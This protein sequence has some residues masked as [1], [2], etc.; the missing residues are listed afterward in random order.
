MFTSWTIPNGAIIH[1]LFYCPT[2]S[3]SSWILAWLNI[4]LPHQWFVVSK[5]LE[6]G[7]NN[8]VTEMSN[9][10]KNCQPL[11]IIR[12]PL[13]LLSL[14]SFLPY[15]ITCS[16]PLLNCASI[17]PTALSEAS[18]CK[19]NS[20]SKSGYAKSGRDVGAAFSFSNA[21]V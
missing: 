14:Q 12:Y 6:I 13:L 20:V 8:V 17:T 7:T 5:H 1:G 16:F 18:H 9:S 11:S 10:T 19:K 21:H 2:S 4:L 15:E 3:C